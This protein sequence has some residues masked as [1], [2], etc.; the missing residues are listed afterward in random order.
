[1]TPKDKIQMQQTLRF[2]RLAE[3]SLERLRGDYHP[4]PLEDRVLAAILECEK[5]LRQP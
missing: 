4:E 2:L 1:M 5:Q 3:Q